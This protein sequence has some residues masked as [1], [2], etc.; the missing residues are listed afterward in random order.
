MIGQS[1]EAPTCLA[2]PLGLDLD[3]LSCAD[4]GCHEATYVVI[5]HIVCA[6]KLSLNATEADG[7][8]FVLISKV[9]PEGRKSRS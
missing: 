5:G 9:I 1:K 7:L 2:R 8:W 3:F 6:T 4:S